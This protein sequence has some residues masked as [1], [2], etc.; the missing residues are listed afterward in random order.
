MGVLDFS[1]LLDAPAGKHGF[2]RVKEKRLYFTDGVRAKFIGFYMPDHET[3]ERL[4]KR[5]PSLCVNVIRLN[6]FDAFPGTA[7]WSVNID[8]PFIRKSG[9]ILR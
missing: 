8:N 1:S 4:S 3:A 9:L 6:A 2:T 7:G 5:L